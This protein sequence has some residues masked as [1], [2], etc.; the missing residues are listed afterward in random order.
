[1]KW[2]KSLSLPHHNIQMQGGRGRNNEAFSKT[3]RRMW[4]Q[5]AKTGNPSLSADISPDGKPH[6]WPLY[7]L[8][9]KQVM[10]FDEFNIHPEKEPEMKLVDRDR[11]YFLTK[12]YLF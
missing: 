6:E 11:T 5:Y 4:V 3:M 7:N 9:D 8:E 10:V 1:M 12:Y 2:R